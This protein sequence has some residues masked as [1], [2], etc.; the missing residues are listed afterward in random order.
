MTSHYFTR[1]PLDQEIIM[2]MAPEGAEA[3][4]EPFYFKTKVVG[5]KELV[6]RWDKEWIRSTRAVRAVKAVK[7]PSASLR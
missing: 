4:I 3:Y 2:A 6:F 7:H 5:K 1:N